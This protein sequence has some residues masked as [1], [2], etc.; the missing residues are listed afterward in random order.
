MNYWAWGGKYIGQRS[1]DILYSSR[2]TPIGRFYD[3]ELYNFQGYYIG[4]I[5]SQNRLIVNKQKKNRR[6]S[7]S[8]KPCSHGGTSYCDYC[9]YVMYAGYENFSVTV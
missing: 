8:S 4:E 7:A 1:G 6:K 3:E 9:G 5:K 2:G